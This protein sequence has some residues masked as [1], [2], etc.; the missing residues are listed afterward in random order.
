[1]NHEALI[2][3]NRNLV[4][5][6]IEELHY[7]ELLEVEAVGGSNEFILRLSTCEYLFNAK[8]GAWGHFWIERESL[9][10]RKDG[11][12][13]SIF[14]KDFIIETRKYTGMSAQT[15]SVFLEEL[16]QTLYSDV[17][18]LERQS[19]TDVSE[20][21]QM[22][23]AQLERYLSGHPKLLLNKG[24]LGWGSAA[25]AEFS[26]ES[27]N[28]FSLVWLAARSSD[29]ILGAPEGL[30][31]DKLLLESLSS[32]EL[33]RFKKRLEADH[34][35]DWIIFPV[36]PWQWE[37]YIKIQ[38]QYE[39]YVKKL[40]Y[41]GQA[42]DQ[43]S[44]QAS[45]RTVSNARRPGAS[46]IKL[47][48]S[49]LNTSCVRGIPP[50]TIA[51]G[52]L[53]SSFIQDIVSSDKLLK[54]AG[55]EILSEKAAL[56]M[57]NS[58]YLGLK[59]APYRY[60]EMLGCVWRDSV[61]GDDKVLYTPMASLFHIQPDGSSLAQEYI[62]RSGLSALDWLRLC[63]EATLIPL[64]HLQLRYGIG[65]VAHGQNVILKLEH[66]RP[67]GAALKDF[68]GDL[69][70][71]EHTESLGLNIPANLLR[72]VKRLKAEHLIHDLITGHLVT[73]LRYVSRVFEEK[74][75]LNEFRFYQLLDDA[76]KTYLESQ[77]ERFLTHPAQNLLRK[78]F[79]KVLVN[80]V[81]F[82]AGYDE[83]S[84]RLT[85]LLGRNLLNPIFSAGNS[86]E[87]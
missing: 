57:P 43:Y 79:E 33:A 52:H 5:K 49:I 53:L 26:P 59:D 51:V 44:P 40:I 61:V 77:E 6:A 34:N 55:V 73:T 70:F 71:G 38:Y 84:Q 76:L 32:C 27:V 19:S 42:G 22:P 63:F 68:H 23:H 80:K 30:D 20:L 35:G 31:W 12:Y 64:Y 83:S 4:A 14:A 17:I 24:R 28:T 67:S 41:L 56:S 8:I 9:R 82:V 46:D 54:T 39:L 86:N 3:A 45:I 1:M 15:I 48:L 87:L 16:D 18:L 81:R 65:L 74:S 37:R 69:R 7:E 29:L 66:Y 62:S 21:A 36:H 75:I 2:L 58:K 85:P 13:Q 25:I 60:K 47:S 50:A 78:E 72:S 10:K 11:V